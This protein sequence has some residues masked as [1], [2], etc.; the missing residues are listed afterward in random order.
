MADK[1]SG[2]I[3]V[4]VLKDESKIRFKGELNYE[5]ADTT[6]KWIYKIHSV[7]ATPAVIFSNSGGDEFFGAA[8]DAIADTDKV[9]WIAIKHS[10][11][12][13]GTNAT[14]EGIM[15]N[16]EAGNAPLWNGT[17]GG[18]TNNMIVGPNEL[19][20]FRPNGTEVQDILVG[21]VKLT[22][23]KASATGTGTVEIYV[24]AIIDDGA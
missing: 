2:G 22:G 6:E 18:H 17:D 24:S 10:G 9:L 13:D 12:S 1:A 21:T 23:N 11:T 5:P 19:F 14:T 3:S 20:V 15:V 7:P 8:S 4:K 16:Y